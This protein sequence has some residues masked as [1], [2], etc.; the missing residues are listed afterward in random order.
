M[1]LDSITFVWGWATVIN[2][3]ILIIWFTIYVLGSDKIY[4]LHVRCFMLSREQFSQLNYFGMMLYKLA[5]F[6]F[7]LAPYISLKFVPS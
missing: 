6:L 3:L 7:L 2:F 1:T 4:Q 5:I